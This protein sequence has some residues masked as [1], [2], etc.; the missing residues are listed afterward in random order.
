[1][2]DS[3]AK[4]TGHGVDE[5]SR[6]ELRAGERNSVFE[7]RENLLT[8][9]SDAT[10][11]KL[12][13]IAKAEGTVHVHALGG[14]GK[15]SLM[16]RELERPNPRISYFNAYASDSSKAF[17]ESMAA[18]FK[19]PYRAGGEDQFSSDLKRFLNGRVLVIDEAGHLLLNLK[20][21]AEIF[22]KWIR[23]H[24]IPII[25]IQPTKYAY[26]PNATR[27]INR[28]LG[29]PIK[30]VPLSLAAPSD[31]EAIFRAMLAE[32]ID[33]FKGIQDNSSEPIDWS[34]V[35]EALLSR[36]AYFYKI[37]G[38]HLGVTKYLL[39]S[40]LSTGGFVDR[41]FVDRLNEEGKE[42]NRKISVLF[43][44]INSAEELL[45]WV[46]N[47]QE[48]NMISGDF[49]RFLTHVFGT[50][51]MENPMLKIFSRFQVPITV[52]GIHLW[53]PAEKQSVQELIDVGLL[54]I[55][56]N[57]IRRR[58]LFVQYEDVWSNFIVEP[59]SNQELRADGGATANPSPELR[60]GYQLTGRWAPAIE[61]MLDNGEQFWPLRP[62][63]FSD[64]GF[65]FR[66]VRA[67]LKKAV[68][69]GR[70]DVYSDE[71][72][73]FY[74]TEERQ[75]SVGFVSESLVD[76]LVI[77][78]FY[79]RQTKD[80]SAVLIF[81]SRVFNKRLTAK[82]AAVHKHKLGP[83]RSP[84]LAVPLEMT[85]VKYVIVRP[86]IKAYYDAILRE[87]EPTDE[88]AAI[89]L[90]L[91]DYQ[92]S[93]VQFLTYNVGNSDGPFGDPIFN[94]IG[95]VVQNL[96]VEPAVWVPA[97]IYPHRAQQPGQDNSRASRENIESP[98]RI[99][100]LRA[101]ETRKT[102]L[103]TTKLETAPHIL[104]PNDP[105]VHF[106][107][108]HLRE[109]ALNPSASREKLSEL[110]ADAGD[111]EVPLLPLVFEDTSAGKP[112][113][114]G[115]TV[116]MP[117]VA[118]RVEANQDLP[119]VAPEDKESLQDAVRLEEAMAPQEK[120]PIPVEELKGW[121]AVQSDSKEEAPELRKV[122]I[123][124][125]PAQAQKRLIITLE[126][127]EGS[128]ELRMAFREAATE[129]RNN[130]ALV[131]VVVSTRHPNG[132]W[133]ERKFLELFGGENL[134]LIGNVVLKSADQLDIASEVPAHVVL[135][136]AIDETRKAVDAQG[137]TSDLAVVGNHSE[138]GKL[139]RL[140]TWLVVGEGSAIDFALLL[141]Q[142]G[143][144]QALTAQ[145]G[146][147]RMITPTRQ[148]MELLSRLF[149]THR[150]PA[151]AA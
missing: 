82:Q 9:G 59:S 41:L 37:S 48:S 50:K 151:S 101:D 5:R 71:G 113:D 122:D 32:R 35:S 90:K 55:D 70:F 67:G 24:K 148:L 68:L 46:F 22:R 54:T 145:F 84:F 2:G 40:F 110:R 56:R 18:H 81:R 31:Y 104:R 119:S 130:R 77:F 139:T 61:Q 142:L 60:T 144:S 117:P 123:P 65:L 29:S 58:T 39:D 8:T 91:L 93:G 36:Q 94:A 127:L 49:D 15:S 75:Y 4:L 13:R 28:E 76:A 20:L 3:S 111:E 86:N 30:T 97:G 23:D 63:K 121:P 25:F 19:I 88:R 141:I 45:R 42:P 140:D 96:P 149:W 10:L 33:Y 146:L 89:K 79:S 52:Q 120:A 128:S 57:F 107:I 108:D 21:C 95:T 44:S 73:T 147:Q 26:I 7:F 38:G 64:D 62:L 135:N 112:A 12:I 92:R 126:A 115:T 106:A 98:E 109:R 136:R 66:T 133:A 47:W 99:S 114:G 143:D 138:L 132:L 34:R 74:G 125:K 78:G 150:L 103:D 14:A 131:F 105:P 69:S 80:D 17:L 87:T 85:D 124:A 134:F 72:G 102:L 27:W 116:A 43:D 16:R 83:D 1:M 118:G 51:R 6:A 11:D 137:L 100:E 53:P 129:H